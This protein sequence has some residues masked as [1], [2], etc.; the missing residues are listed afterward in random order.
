MNYLIS[1]KSG[2]IG[3]AIAKYLI[4]KGQNVYGIPRDL[5]IE[6]LIQYFKEHK[7]DY[8]IHLGSYG[9]HYDSQKDFRQMVETNIMGTYN[10]L[11]A[12]KTTDYKL[13]YN[14]STSAVCPSYYY[15][16]K[17]CGE[18][19][20]EMYNRTVNCIP[21]S[22]YGPGEASHKFIPTV[23]RGLLSGEQIVV[24]EKATHDWIYISDLVEALSVGET[25]LGTG[26]KTTNK[27]VVRMLEDISGK[28]LNYVSGKLRSYD[29][30]NWKASKGVSH[31]NLY[32]GLKRTYE[33]YTR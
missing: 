3:S 18:K 20:T 29:N 27:E 24:D 4:D 1:G 17:L 2:F 11:E 5:S 30:N 16:T 26:I 22:V 28:K 21:Y 23:I 7:P 6:A 33:Y 25:E 10:L 32:E 9:N 12:A 8:I 13:I 31:I 14:F 15:I 19:L